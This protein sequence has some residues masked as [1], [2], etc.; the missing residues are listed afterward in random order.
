MRKAHS[1]KKIEHGLNGLNGFNGFA[2]MEFGTGRNMLGLG[3]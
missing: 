3:R 1:F 2:R